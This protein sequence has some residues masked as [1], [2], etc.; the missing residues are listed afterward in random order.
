MDPQ[1]Q[2]P[3]NGSGHNSPEPVVLPPDELQ[4]EL[5]QMY[6]PR[7]RYM[8]HF[9][10]LLLTMF[11]TMVVGARMQDCFNHHQLLFFGDK[12]FFPLK[13]IL[14]DPRR[15]LMGLPYSLSLLGILFA[16]EMGHYL[17]C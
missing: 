11:T 12:D 9:I 7:P 17:M 10:F 14:E 13:W 2:L 15:L 3:V 8:R 4:E 16:H 1:E 5:R 6:A